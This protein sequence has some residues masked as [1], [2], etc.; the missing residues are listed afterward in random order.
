MRE[1]LEGAVVLCFRLED[2]H[3]G[4]ADDFALVFGVNDAAQ[5]LKEPLGGVGM[6]ERD[7]EC[8]TEGFHDLFCFARTQEA[9]VHEDTRQP[10]ADSTMHQHRR[11]RGIYPAAEGA[12]YSPVVAHLGANVLYRLLDE[13]RARPVARATAG[14]GEEV[15]QQLH[16]APRMH[17][18]RVEQHAAHPS[19]CRGGDGRTIGG[20]ERLPSRRHGGDVVAVAHPDFH[21]RGEARRTRVSGAVTST[22]AGPYSE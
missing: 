3:E 19:I 21:L 20:S 22:V 2:A 6:D 13:V 4:L 10:L 12:Q 14:V 11:D 1:E 9:V 8:F 7:A 15:S 16:A 17:H 5:F 18:F